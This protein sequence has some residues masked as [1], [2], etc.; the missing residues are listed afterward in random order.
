MGQ[1]PSTQMQDFVSTSFVRAV[2]DESSSLIT[3]EIFELNYE[4]FLEKLGE[5]NKL[6]TANCS[7]IPHLTRTFHLQI[8]KIFRF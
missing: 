1:N 6:Y 3:D 8:K 2:T 5:L 4:E 7:S